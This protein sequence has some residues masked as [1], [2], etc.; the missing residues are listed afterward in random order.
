ML[1]KK[2]KDLIEKVVTGG[3]AT[4]QSMT[5]DPVGGTATLPNSK[6][7]GEGMQKVASITPGQGEEET[8]TE[9]N[10]KATG[11]MSASNK[12][13]VAMKSGAA[14]SKME[15]AD[16]ASELKQ[17]FGEEA[18]PE[19]IEKTSTLFEA[20]V[21]L[22]VNEI[23]EAYEAALA[24]EVETIREDYAAKID[25][26]LSYVAEEWK[27]ENEVAIETSLKNELTEE[28]IEGLKNLFAEHYIEIPSDKVDVLEAMAQKVEELETRLNESLAGSIE[29][30]K[31]IAQH[32][33][34]D[35]FD[36]VSEGLALSQV[37]KF[38][39]LAESIEYSDAASY[40]QKLELV[41]ENFLSDKKPAAQSNILTEEFESNETQPNVS[42]SKDMNKYV[43]AISRTLKK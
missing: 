40:Q 22:K 5:A 36:T 12:A 15:E 3:G 19:F 1:S 17:L 26:Y 20:A 10:T 35:V 33:M 34:Q 8:S 6:K 25:E 14:S 18:T 9:N 13:S 39:T 4:G 31:E 30:K 11:D 37:E 38:R 42:L 21:A 7:Q 27:S 23:Q 41:K 16:V 28:F 43:S 2:E 29:L 24:E 32:E